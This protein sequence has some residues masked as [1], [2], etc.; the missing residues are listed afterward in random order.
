MA[1][2]Y[3]P[4]MKV[5]QTAFVYNNGFRIYFNNPNGWENIQEVQLRL[6]YQNDNTSALNK[7]CYKNEIICFRK[8][9][10]EENPPSTVPNYQLVTKN[11]TYIKLN[12]GNYIAEEYKPDVDKKSDQY[13]TIQ[14]RFSTVSDYPINGSN[15]SSSQGTIITGDYKYSPSA[16]YLNENVDN[17]SEWSRVSLIKAIYYPGAK[18][19]TEPFVKQNTDDEEY[20]VTSDTLDIF[21]CINWYEEKYDETLNDQKII[22]NSLEYLNKFEVIL[23]EVLFENIHI[24]Y[25]SG[26]IST[27]NLERDTFFDTIQYKLQENIHYHLSINFKTNNDYFFGNDYFFV[28]QES[29]DHTNLEISAEED[30]KNGLN[31]IIIRD[32]NNTLSSL[33]EKDY[34]IIKRQ[35]NK[36]NFSTWDDF[37]FGKP[38]QLIQEDNKY[39]WYDKTIESGYFYKYGI[40]K[41]DKDTGM[42]TPT[43]VS[44]SVMQVFDDMYLTTKD[45]QLNIKFDPK[46]SSFKRNIVETK[47]DT[48][49]SQYPF[50]RRNGH[51]DYRQ[52]TIGGL[53]TAFCDEDNVFIKVE[54]LYG[55]STIAENYKTYNNNNNI[56]KY[57]DF[58]YER[59]FR[60][61]ILDFLHKDNVKLF[62]STPEGNILVRLMD[63]SLEP[64]QVLGR[65]LYSFS[66]TA[67]EVADCTVENYDKYDI[68]VYEIAPNIDPWDERKYYESR[69]EGNE[70]DSQQEQEG[71]IEPVPDEYEEGGNS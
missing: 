63:I 24:F 7:N 37:F 25:N 15:E 30:Y 26:W 29:S 3:P 70:D 42:R 32:D 8:Y 57:N 41:F 55:N 49:G 1:F 19:F 43:V 46:I 23:S 66:A 61:K 69:K 60:N 18:V 53:I 38:E 28:Y 65:M 35:S 67:Y 48:I 33:P 21:G 45:M 20:I 68:M 34:I 36:D 51:I 27:N 64:Q 62:R 71:P 5:N 47:I 31:K 9:E 6:N 50:I 4:T 2:L 54:D 39:I 17:F 10:N 40:Q 44:N 11:G 22:N 16:N 59:A 58:I 52:F 14:L 13:F 56:N 12:I